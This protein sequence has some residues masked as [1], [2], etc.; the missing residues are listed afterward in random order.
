VQFYRRETPLLLETSREC[1]IFFG[2]PI[3]FAGEN[4]SR[5]QSAKT[6][7]NAC[8]AITSPLRSRAI[9]LNVSAVSNRQITEEIQAKGAVA[10]GAASECGNFPD[11]IAV[12][13]VGV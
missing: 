9:G 4:Y 7:T 2:S 10:I 12:W 3:I 13:Q 5:S 6:R 11:T 1:C 8:R